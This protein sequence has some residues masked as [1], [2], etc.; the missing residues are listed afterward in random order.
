MGALLS[1]LYDNEQ[2]LLLALTASSVHENDLIDIA[3]LSF[4]FKKYTYFLPS[5]VLYLLMNNVSMWSMKYM[6][7]KWTKKWR[8]WR[9]DGGVAG[10][11]SD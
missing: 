4:L 9:Y 5:Y 3:C 6:H 8:W 11:D 7:T 1:I 2:K 10:D